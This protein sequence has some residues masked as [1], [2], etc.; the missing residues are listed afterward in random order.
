MPTERHQSDSPSS[1]KA[2]SRS[3]QSNLKQREYRDAQGEV[4]H[5]TRSYMEQHAGTSSQP[6]ATAKGKQAARADSSDGRGGGAS[7]GEEALEL[8]ESEDE[9][10]AR[11]APLIALA[12]MDSEAAAAYEIAAELIDSPEVESQIRQFADDHRRHIRDLAQLVEQLGGTPLAASPPPE[13]STFAMFAS[14]LG[15]LGTQGALLSLINSE[16]F[17]NATYET[18]LQLMLEADGREL[19]ERNFSDEQRHISWLS[20]QARELGDVDDPTEAEDA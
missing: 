9:L 19:L 4:H 14:A 20:A 7:R 10:E 15:A 18:A 5:H 8:E 12:Q 2:G 3:S 6:E 17:T 16:Q 1:S 11:I 13:S